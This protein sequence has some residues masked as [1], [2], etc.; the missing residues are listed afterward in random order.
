MKTKVNEIPLVGPKGRKELL[1]KIG[2]LEKKVAAFENNPK[3]ESHLLRILSTSDN[4]E[5]ESAALSRLELD[6]KAATINDLMSIDIR[7]TIVYSEGLG[8]YMT[9]Q[10]FSSDAAING[11]TFDGGSYVDGAGTQ[12]WINICGDV[13]EV[14]T[15]EF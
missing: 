5:S 2:E 12:F 4:S 11:V 8:V 6:G 7:N 15:Y 14:R 1:Y 13:S 10:S 3:S 9:I